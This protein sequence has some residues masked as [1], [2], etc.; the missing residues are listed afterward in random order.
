MTFNR[1]SVTSIDCDKNSVTIENNEKKEHS[2]SYDY[3]VLSPGSQPRSDLIPGAIEHAIPFYT[4]DNAYQLKI[5]I[6]ECLN[7]AKELIRVVVVGGGY[8]GVEVA[9][10]V[11]ELL[12]K[13][14]GN[15]CIVDRNS[16]LLANSP[17][18]NRITA[19]R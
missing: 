4:V 18:H 2:L 5:K 8:S 7:S 15:V 10:N 1:G 19:E 9:T 13:K 17:E 11:A 3:L 6:N 16:K 14:R 12:G